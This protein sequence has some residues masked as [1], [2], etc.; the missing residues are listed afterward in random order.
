MSNALAI[1]GVTRVLRELLNEGLV[2]QGV[3][4]LLGSTVLVT[5]LPPDRI[6]TVANGTEATSLNLFLRQVSPNLGWRNEAL[7]SLDA[8]GRGRLSNP[9]L[10]LDL[11][12]LVSAHGTEEC[13]PRSCSAT[14]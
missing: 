5:T 14:P 7:P 12:Y 13:T 4:G 11:H 8:A 2:N 3:A 10:A 1:A 6:T 9:P